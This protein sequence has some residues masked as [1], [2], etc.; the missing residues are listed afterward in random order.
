MQ[1]GLD[2]KVG[3]EKEKAEQPC[4]ALT[5]NYPNKKLAELFFCIRHYISRNLL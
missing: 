1:F 3:T 4:S 2:L 5:P